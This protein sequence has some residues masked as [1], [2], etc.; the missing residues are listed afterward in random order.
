MA[1]EVVRR[2]PPALTLRA[3]SE[4]SGPQLILENRSDETVSLKK[5]VQI[6]GQHE[7]GWRSEGQMKLRFDCSEA[8]PDCVDL[9]P[10][11]ELRPPPWH[12]TQTDSG[13]CACDGCEPLPAG[14]YRWRLEA[15][16]GAYEVLGEPFAITEDQ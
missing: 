2:P 7:A 8:P 9:V 12:Q 11:G 13:Q 1:E 3:E 4:A 16:D 6:Q 5:L 10:G 15:C 14:T